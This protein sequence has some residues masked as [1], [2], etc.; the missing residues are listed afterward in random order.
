MHPNNV[1]SA[2][3][4]GSEGVVRDPDSPINGNVRNTSRAVGKPKSAV[5]RE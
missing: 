5:E 3:Y 2:K 1:R 4:A